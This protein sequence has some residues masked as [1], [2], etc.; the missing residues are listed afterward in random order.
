M[1]LI[2]AMRSVDPRVPV[3]PALAHVYLKFSLGPL[4]LPSLI[5]PQEFAWIDALESQPQVRVA[6]QHSAQ[7]RHI[8]HAAAGAE[9]IQERDGADNHH[10]VLGLYGKQKAHQNDAVRIEH[11]KSQQKSVDRAR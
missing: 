2:S 10:E 8:A 4:Q 6:E 1:M 9:G 3:R 11:S 5:A 7:M